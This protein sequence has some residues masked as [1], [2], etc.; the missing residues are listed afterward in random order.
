MLHEQFINILFAIMTM[1]Y[2]L[3]ISRYKDDIVITRDRGGAKVEC[4]NNDIIRV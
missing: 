3:V 2:V 4:N 1:K